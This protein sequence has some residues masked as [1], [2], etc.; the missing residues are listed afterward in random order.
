MKIKVSVSVFDQRSAHSVLKMKSVRA[1]EIPFD[2]FLKCLQLI[3]RLSDV[4]IQTHG[5]AVTK[6]KDVAYPLKKIPVTCTC[7]SSFHIQCR[8]LSI[9]ILKSSTHL[10]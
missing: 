10:S 7:T 2:T 5:F 9:R 3:L 6:Q 1:L 8:Q 4:G